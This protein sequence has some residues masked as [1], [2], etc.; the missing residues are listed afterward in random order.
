EALVGRAHLGDVVG[1]HERHGGAHGERVHRGDDVAGLP[2]A[3]EVERADDRGASRPGDD[4]PAAGELQERLPYGR[5]AAAEP[6]G[7]L[8]VAQLLAGGEGAVDDRLAERA[9]H[10]V[11]EQ[12][13]AGARS[14]GGDGPRRILR[15][16]CRG[17]RPVLAALSAARTISP[18]AR[19]PA[20]ATPA[21]TGS[22]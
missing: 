17:A 21:T 10:V 13:A 19:A 15:T 1:G 22:R 16:P 8:P 9:E 7:E 2:H 6:L 11:A 14:V 5:P 20:S 3:V 4:E 12:G 18:A